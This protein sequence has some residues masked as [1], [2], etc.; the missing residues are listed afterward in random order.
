MKALLLLRSRRIAAKFMRFFFLWACV[1]CTASA[2]LA[3]T[4]ASAP[5][6]AKQS[7][8]EAH[9]IPSRDFDTKHIKLDLRFDWEH[10]QAI[11]VETI[12][13]SPL[14]TNL[15]NIELDAANMTFASVKLVSGE[16]LKFESDSAKQ[17]LKIAL[18]KAY[19]PA[20]DITLV[21]DYR[22]NGPTKESGLLGVFGG[23]LTFIKPTSADPRRPRQIWSQGES[24]YNHNWFACYD[25]PNDFTTSELI[26]TVEKPF[27]VISNGKLVAQKQNADGTRT[28]HWRIDQPHAVYLTSI[29]VGEY[30]PIEASYAGIPVTT[31]V[32]PREA[33]EGKLSA[34]RI[35]DMVKLFSEKTG[36]K[37]PYA[38]YAQT[39]VRDFG[40]GMENISATTLTDRA[41]HDART[42]LDE[43]SDSLLSHELAH[44]WFGDFVTCRE[45][46]DIWL[47]ESFATYFQALWD[48]HYLGHDDFLYQDVKANQ[49]TYYKAWAGG[50]RRPIVTK[51]YVDQNTIFDVYAYP[52]GGA[53]LHMLR[54][55]LGDDNWWRA[56]N[57]YLTKNAHQPVSTEQ[58]RIAIEE[59]TGQSMDWFFDEWVYKMGHPRFNV[60]QSYDEASKSLKL[61]VKQ[62]QE[63]DQNSEYPQVK[64]FRTP[65]DIE[66]TT[67]TGTRIERVNIE[68]RA[69]QSFTFSVDSKP[70]LVNF[71]YGNTVIKELKFDKLITDLIYQLSKDQ[72]T[73]GRVW[74]AEELAHRLG[75]SSTSDADRKQ[76]ISALTASVK[77]DKF[78][79]VRLESVKALA[80][81]S[82]VEAK[83]ALTMVALKDPKS[84]VRA[85]AINSLSKSKDAALAPVFAQA[86]NDQSYNV[87]RAAAR[88]LGATKDPSSYNALSKLLTTESWRDNILA[89]GLT[90][91][92]ELGDK[93]ALDLGLKYSATGN[94][95][96]TRN[97]ALALVGAVGKDDPRAFETISSAF[98]EGVDTADL[99][100]VNAAG[101][102]FVKLGDKRAIEQIIDARKKA[103][104]SIELQTILG[105]YEAQ[106]TD[107][108]KV[109]K[110]T[111]SAN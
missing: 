109:S 99:R 48:E 63:I 20:Q 52:R 93:R 53:V 35:A 61:L 102:A 17:K 67:S 72:D 66:I 98:H 14:L 50:A 24:E 38:K 108:T 77:N 100:L 94:L 74:A 106:L 18:N 68:P 6:S 87:I 96:R 84:A 57:H 33:A 64:F 16:S 104:G 45:W 15:H 88:S 81:A 111:A 47:N 103:E 21:I 8:P 34:A 90:G 32:Y 39:M 55:F 107:P 73:Q 89:S 5:S 105:G 65:L 78:W 59:A 76:I 7:L 82:A 26:A 23:G 69:E 28:F 110:P 51:N 62:E 25:H 43:T 22:T 3:Q 71:D 31:Y 85:E 13:L 11:G 86:L 42:E 37:Y 9:Y 12:T 46:A 75:G 49:D 54:T 91:L 2:S 101:E 56:I 36:V 4:T 70:V 95:S 27:T 97:A 40:G 58:L 79:G 60:T 19:Q 83:D 1:I 29:V 44:Q 30:L 92:G 10:E 80:G 41:V